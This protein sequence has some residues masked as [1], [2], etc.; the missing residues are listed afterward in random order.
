MTRGSILGLVALTAVAAACGKKNDPLPP[1]RPIPAA[2][3]DF[4]AERDGQQVTLRFTVP[5][6]NADG[7]SPVAI[8]RVE[9]YAVT[10][11]DTAK[12][13][14]AADVAVAANLL[15]TIAVRPAPADEPIAATDPKT[16]VAG[17][18]VRHTETITLLPDAAPTIARAYVAV[19]AIGRR[20]SMTSPMLV[21]PL[22]GAA[23]A[24]PAPI[25]ISYTEDLVTLTWAAGAEGT[26]FIVERAAATGAAPVRLTPQAT[27][28]TSLSLP[29]ELGREICVTLRAVSVTGAVSMVSEPST[30]TCATPVDKFPPASPTGLVGTAAESAIELVW[31]PSLNKDVAGYIVLRGEG[32]GGT[33]LRLTPEPVT[34]TTYRDVS[35][36]PGVTYEYAVIAVDT[37]K[38]PNES[39]PSNRE[40]VTARETGQR[41]KGTGQ[42]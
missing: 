21:V 35:V 25:N 41:A 24:G 22:A 4:S 18:V 27:A 9:I 3:S 14:V 10:L 16:P 33:L 40:T 20:R 32:A 11:A 1:A 42:R 39:G 6:A 31:R 15:T 13:S 8:D 28:Q 23:V 37:A 12:P 5:K 30:A 19:P 2:L 34:S 29:I 17:D 36:R 38:P 26:R 7:T